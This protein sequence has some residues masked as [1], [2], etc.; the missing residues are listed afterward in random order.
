MVGQPQL[1]RG[2]TTLVVPV[3]PSHTFPASRKRPFLRIALVLVVVG[4]LSSLLVVG[5]VPRL[6]RQD[7]LAAAEAEQSAARR[8]NVTQP[9]PAPQSELTL[10]ATIQGYQATDLHA[11]ASGYLKSWKTDIGE[12]VTAGEVLAEID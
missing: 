8:V 6:E 9:V 1:R 5:I 3:A 12:H 4:V 11:R 10:P 7:R 2:R